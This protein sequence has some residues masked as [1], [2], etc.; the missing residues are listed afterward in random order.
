MKLLL[1][2][3]LAVTRHDVSWFPKSVKALSKGNKIKDSYATNT[4]F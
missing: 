3:T 1:S 4:Q 2:Y